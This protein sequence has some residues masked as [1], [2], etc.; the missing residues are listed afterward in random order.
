[1]SATKSAPVVVSFAFLNSEESAQMGNPS[2]YLSALVTDDTAHFVAG[3]SLKAR[4]ALLA[5]QTRSD[6][7]ATV[8]AVALMADDIKGRAYKRLH[9]ACEQA[10]APHTIKSRK[11]MSELF[12][13]DRVQVRQLTTEEQTEAATAKA[14]IEAD[15][16]ETAE[17]AEAVKI[18]A[19]R[20]PLEK[21]IAE[22]AATIAE[23]AAT[24]AELR[25]ALTVASDEL[26][27]RNSIAT[28]APRTR[29]KPAQ[30]VRTAA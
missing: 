23:Q 24:I 21:T 28:D 19:I 1:M 22:Q 16:V 8:A 6:F 26:M 9:E 13:A 20:A 17:K 29:A 2:L 14:K 4:W 15:R 10:N 11:A 30:R 25:A 12:A 5:R 7:E 27:K 18:A 3:Q